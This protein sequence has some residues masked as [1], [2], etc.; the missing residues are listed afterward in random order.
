MRDFNLYITS[1]VESV[2]IDDA[3]TMEAAVEIKLPAT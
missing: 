3:W 2:F 1:A